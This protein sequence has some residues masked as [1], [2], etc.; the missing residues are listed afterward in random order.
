MLKR[1]MAAGLLVLAAQGPAA[2][3]HALGGQGPYDPAV[4]TPRSVLGYELG[5][6]FTP[7]HLLMRYVEAVARSSPRVRLDTVAHSFEG[8]EVVL[9]TVA[10]EGNAARLDDVR[11]DA[12]RLADPRGASAAELAAVRDRIPA[13]AW[14][15]YTVHGPEA[16]GAEAALGVLYQLAA[17]RDEETRRI[18]ENVVVLIDPLQNPDG[19]ERHGSCANGAGGAD[20][21]CG[22]AG[23][24][25]LIG[26]AKADILR[27]AAGNDV[28]VGGPGRDLC[29][30]GPGRD[31]AFGCAKVRSV[32]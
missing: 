1:S 23:D 11:R 19:H 28:L 30:G 22:S 9:V 3:Q 7:H 6:R 24:D 29:V 18:L 2:A 16:S 32:P 17:G 12:A 26:G 8:R 25:R 5:E 10:S 27:G 31:R 14:L 13:I 20:T 4:P 21:A 15:G